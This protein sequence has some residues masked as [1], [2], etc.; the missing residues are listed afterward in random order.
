MAD[1]PSIIAI[2]KP[3][4]PAPPA[5]P[6]PPGL[7]KDAKWED[8]IFN[9]IF[10]GE[11]RINTLLKIGRD[12]GGT[13]KKKVRAAVLKYLEI[14][15]PAGGVECERQRNRN[16][17]AK[18]DKPDESFTGRYESTGGSNGRYFWAINQ[19]GNVVIAIRTMR[20][21]STSDKGDASQKYL[22]LR[23][24]LQ[25]NRTAAMF[26]ANDPGRFWGYLQPISRTEVRWHY[27]SYLDVDGKRVDV[28]GHSYDDEH[29]K[30]V[31]GRPT[32]MKSLYLS[33]DHSL[34]VLMQEA[35][36]FPLTAER[37]QFLE[38]GARSSLLRTLLE[39]Y[40]KT[41]DGVTSEEKR[42]KDSATARLVAYMANL[43]WDGQPSTKA[44][45]LTLPPALE[46]AYRKELAAYLKRA[47]GIAYG[48]H[49]NL[50]LATHVAKIWLA[51]EKLN[52]GQVKR[53]FLDWLIHIAQ[54]RNTKG[55][56][57]ER[58]AKTLSR[59]LEIPLTRSSGTYRYRMKLD[60]YSFL[61]FRV[62]GTLLVEPLTVPKWGATSYDVS[63][64]WIG[65][66]VIFAEHDEVFDVEKEMPQQWLKEDFEG[67]L[68]IGELTFAVKTPWFDFDL[69]DLHG[70]YLKSKNGL[71]L[72]IEEW[73]T[74]PSV[75]PG[76]GKTPKKPWK[77]SGGFIRASVSLAKSKLIDLSKPYP[78]S[79][80]LTRNLD[81]AQHFCF[82]D[83]FLTAAGRQYLRLVC[84]D[85]LAAF[86]STTVD[87]A[88]MGHADRPSRAGPKLNEEL[89]L[90]R[91]E[92]V[93]TA[94]QDILGEQ[95]KIPPK[96]IRTL[97]FGDLEQWFADWLKSFPD[98]TIA[99]PARDPYR[100]RVD[101]FINAK[102]VATFR[103][104]L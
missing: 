18:P 75:G 47:R 32:L 98:K 8:A 73:D 67:T 54:D 44:D 5:P 29:L 9:A 12:A 39:G 45:A 41:P 77:V 103:D 80:E 84:A 99:K 76:S 49:N 69:V 64:W 34:N 100:R 31:S 16:A 83:A 101:L 30:L 20:D 60:L 2:K 28:E 97:G 42:T 70:V 94:L 86:S 35:E 59:L 1:T 52:Y 27:G 55:W 57:G 14:P 62:E 53:S 13:D 79:K 33:G 22:E 58:H 104:H 38:E 4:P 72:D 19:A 21:Y 17:D 90:R 92:N 82:G 81:S 63:G 93:K 66:P 23:G 96:D 78:E 10:N 48:H 36:W 65:P 3:T 89:S 37:Y 68:Y 102:L 71:L 95:L 11:R 50:S 40:V 51:H 6:R 24:D 61:G 15:F 46:E 91:A 43:L 88:I 85:Q 87:V 74:D 56:L 26:V 7:A 25:G